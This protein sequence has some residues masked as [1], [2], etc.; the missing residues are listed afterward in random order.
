MRAL[1]LLAILILCAGAVGV[2]FHYCT[3]AVRN[4]RGSVRTHMDALP[5]GLRL[6]WPV[7]SF[8]QF[9]ILQIAPTSKLIKCKKQLEVAGLG[10]LIKEADFIAIQV[11]CGFIFPLLSLAMANLLQATIGTKILLFLGFGYFGWIYPLIWMRDKK[12]KRNK[13]IMRSLPSCDNLS[14][15]VNEY[16]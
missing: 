13:E 6:I 14:I 10:F 16:I 8:L 11:V 7:V 15:T 4:A 1:L 5:I 2:V 12:Q 3:R 9:Y